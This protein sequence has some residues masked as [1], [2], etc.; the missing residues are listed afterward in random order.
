MYSSEKWPTI[1]LQSFRKEFPRAR[2]SFLN[3]QSPQN[4]EL[5]SV[6]QCS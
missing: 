5:V 6:T 4:E 3:A 1:S 2:Q